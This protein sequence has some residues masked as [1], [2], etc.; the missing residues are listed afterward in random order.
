MTWNLE[1]LTHALRDANR[2]DERVRQRVIDAIE[3]FATTGYGDVIPSEEAP[4]NGA[5]GSATGA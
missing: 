4:T 5:C 1:W 2:L 3:R